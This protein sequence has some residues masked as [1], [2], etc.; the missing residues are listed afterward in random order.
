HGGGGAA[1][2][3]GGDHPPSRTAESRPRDRERRRRRALLA[4]HEP[5]DQRPRGAHGGALRP[6]RAPQGPGGP[7]RGGRARTRTRSWRGARVSD[8]I[9]VAGGRLVDP[10]ARTVAAE[11][12]LLEGGRIAARGPA[13]TVEAEARTLDARGLLVLPG[14]VDMHVHLR[15]P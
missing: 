11:D 15:E 9:L 14:L 3:A 8:R 13:G 5:G 4:D 7:R 1:R 6:D 12:L 2:E 10:V